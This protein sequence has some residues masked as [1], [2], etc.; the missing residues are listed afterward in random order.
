MAIQRSAAE[1]AYVDAFGRLPEPLR[2]GSRKDAFEHFAAIGLPHRRLED[3]K[4]TDLRQVLDRAYPPLIEPVKPSADAGKLLARSP[5]AGAARARLV[6]IDGR[7]DARRSSL[8]QSGD[9]S[10]RA[11]GSDGR[12]SGEKGD[13]ISAL[14]IAFAT[15]G[16]H[17]RIGKGNA[18]D[19]PIELVFISTVSERVTVTTRNVIEVEDGATA[20]LLEYHVGPDTAYVASSVT[21]ARL[22]KG[23][24]LDRVK[25]AED[26]L[27]AVHLANFEVRLG[28]GASLRDFT[29][30]E[31][32]RVT[33]QQGFVTFE[34]E[35]AEARIGG[36]YLLGGAQHADT[37]LVVDH[38]VPHC[39]SRELFKCVM[40]E[41]AR[42]VFQ[43]KV[44]VRQK[45]QKT[46][47]KQSSHGLLLSP[48]AE[49]DTKPEL[50][51]FAD[52][53]VCGHGATSG[54]LNEDQLFYL[55]A[56]GIP[57][58]EA[59]SLL[60]AAFAAEAFDMVEND[61]VRDALA[62]IAASWL[63]RRRK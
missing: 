24:R 39:T 28:E 11:L 58:E 59:K 46:D 8:P 18:I 29:L 50:E 62:G 12:F 52:D 57:D 60:V 63:A 16:A 53:V 22:G 36:T 37:R 9:V 40:D 14:N 19:A 49:F 38:A 26:G 7:F 27:K 54:E 47:G 17:V 31:G 45:A 34:G 44:V 6:F 10:A 21:E 56:R 33:R 43:G 13:P 25:V 1:A 61:A 51:I 3:W 15:D 30:I 5:F 32:A 20:T 4:W 35:H 23:A 2:R 41:N 42:G 48:T 55:R